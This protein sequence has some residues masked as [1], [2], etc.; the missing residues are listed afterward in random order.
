MDTNILIL[1]IYLWLSGIISGYF[2]GSQWDWFPD[3]GERIRNIAISILLLFIGLPLIVSGFLVILVSRIFKGID[4]NFQI[5]FYF[6]HFIMNGHYNMDKSILYDFNYIAKRVNKKSLR[7]RIMIHCTKLA[8]GR[9]NYVYNEKG[10][11]T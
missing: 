7:G 10:T 2:L 3:K 8:N 9:N 11:I 4:R 6:V 5:S 1:F